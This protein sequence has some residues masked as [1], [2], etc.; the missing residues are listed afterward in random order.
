M[1]SSYILHFVL[2]EFEKKDLP[3]I[4]CFC[5]LSFPGLFMYRKALEVRFSY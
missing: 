2:S 4:S 3:S 1:E 5:A